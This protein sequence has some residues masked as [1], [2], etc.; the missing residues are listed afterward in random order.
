MGANG[1][2]AGDSGIISENG[3]KLVN[4]AADLREK[5]SML[6]SEVDEITEEGIFGD[7]AATLLSV[8]YDLDQGLNKYA[9]TLDVLGSNVKTSAS[10]LEEIDTTH[11]S[12]LT[13]EG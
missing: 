6:K 3:A 5:L 12:G 2:I 13:Y 4:F 11:S 9:E 10:N 1:M 8:Y 7:S